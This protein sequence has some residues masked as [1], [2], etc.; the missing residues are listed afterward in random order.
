M[1]SVGNQS[2]N[3]S[4]DGVIYYGSYI[5]D[6]NEDG[7]IDVSDLSVFV[8]AWPTIDLGPVTGQA[9][10][11]YPQLD[12]ITDLTDM[13]VFG[14]M[15]HW[16]HQTGGSSPRIIENEGLNPVI[17]QQGNELVVTFPENTIAGQ[18][19]IGYQD[20][21]TMPTI[22]NEQAAN[23][24]HILLTYNDPENMIT[25]ME[26]GY[27]AEAQSRVIKYGLDFNSNESKKIDISYMLYGPDGEL[28]GQGSLTKELTPVPEKYA[29]HQNYPNPFNPVTTIRYDLPQESHVHLVIYD[30]L[31]REV[32]TLVNSK[33]QAGYK[34][35]RWDGRNNFGQKVSAGM[36][37]YRIQASSFSKVQKMVLLK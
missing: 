21:N 13:M 32:K 24:D 22:L 34:S 25:V 26:I 30:I 9:P 17:E 1:D 37:F 2:N 11:F 29:L 33:E 5:A 8:S 3:V 7:M 10:Y 31:G 19:K 18:F 14:R 36:Y 28:L 12:G 35:I 15:W 4:G 27:I 20:L 6:F 16:S 23:E